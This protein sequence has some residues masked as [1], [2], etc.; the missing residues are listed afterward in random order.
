MSISHADVRFKVLSRLRTTILQVIDD[1]RKTK[2]QAYKRLQK[3]LDEFSNIIKSGRDIPLIIKNERI[4]KGVG[5]PDIEVFGG[6][7]LIE[8]KVKLSEFQSGLK[9]IERYVKH[10][11]YAEYAIIT[12]FDEWEYYRVDKS[13]L[14]PVKTDLNRIVEE[15]LLK[16][17]RVALSTENVGN[18]FAPVRLAEDELHKIFNAYNLRNEALFGAYRN[19]IRRLYEG[20]SEEDVERLFIKHT[21]MQ[22]IVSSCLTVSSGKTT[23]PV[24]ACSGEEIAAEIVLPYLKWWQ[25]LLLSQEMSES[26]RDFLVSLAESIYSRTLLLDWESGCKEDIFR[27]LYEI[28]IDE[29]TR[30]RIGEYYTPLWLAEYI[31]GKIQR[32]AEGLKGR[33]VLDPFCGSGTFLVSAFYQKISEGEEAENAIKELVG[34]DINPLAVSIARAELMIAY[35]N[36]K[37][38]T[39]TPL[40]FNTDSTNFLLRARGTW[41]PTSFLDELIEIEKN[42]E[43]LRSSHIHLTTAKQSDFSDILKLEV[44]LRDCFRDV[45]QLSNI[46]DELKCRLEALKKAGFGGIFSNIVDVLNRENNIDSLSRLIEKYGNG[47][48]AVSITS[49]FAPYILREIKVDIVVS[50]PPW[51]LLTEPKGAYGDL[52]R[53]VAKGLLGGYSKAG[54]ILAGS[55]ISSVFLYGCIQLLKDD[56]RIGFLMPDEAVYT[57]GSYY[58]LGKLLTYEAIKDHCGELIQVKFD[59]FKHGRLPSIVFIKKQEGQI[60]CGSMNV[61]F[62]REYS[63]ALHLSEVKCSVVVNGNYEDYIRKARLYTET[64]TKEIRDKLGVSEVFPMGDYIRGLFGGIK[65]KGAR[66][67]AGLV[68][69]VVDFDRL[70]GQYIIRLS[71]TDTPLKMPQPY[72]KPFW[73]K[74]IYEGMIYPFYL[75]DVYNV[76]LS[77]EGK[78]KT[79]MFLRNFVLSRMSGE[80][81]EKVKTL[82]EEFSQPLKLKELE[83]KYYVIYRCIR[84]FVS[85]VISPKDIRELTPLIVESHCS[86]ISLEDEQQAYY[87]SSLLNYLAYK[88][89]EN[90][91]AFIRNQFLRPLM[92]IAELDIEWSSEKWQLKVAELSR[93]LQQ[94][95]PKCYKGFIKRGMRVDRCFERLKSCNETKS[96]FMELIDTIDKAVNKNKLMDALRF[97]CKLKS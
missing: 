80:D 68:F 87:Y 89:I 94:E 64:P 77:S 47:V 75:H 34:F 38:Q 70:S 95:A 1:I 29:G 33:I 51:M 63:K 27:E 93:K 7:I 65:K 96:L 88:V 45:S 72:L 35:Q 4:L 23:S 66:N 44:V 61:E 32:D 91:G 53:E 46:K 37:K 58:G 54:Q 86:L 11:A 2:P 59:A 74:L 82:L 10:Y 71:G 40:I 78:E 5:K 79:E 9:Q 13:K 81:R 55:D 31:T 92:A 39:V 56:G 52:L 69:E 19:I 6:R 84:N 67:Y 15:V 8:V 73:K 76:L 30:R 28:L 3:H 85:F 57:E 22:M 26:D 50:N 48:W 83:E 60:V 90:K 62:E 49:I 16:D 25:I 20:A 97:V 21:L 17:V 43:D 12:N 41:E 24:R 18:L 36:V 42:V 14:I